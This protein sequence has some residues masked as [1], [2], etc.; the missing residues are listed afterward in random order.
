LESLKQS[1]QNHE[2][3]KEIF[4]LMKK[5]IQ[6]LIERMEINKRINNK[7]YELTVILRQKVLGKH[8]TFLIFIHFKRSKLIPVYDDPL[9]VSVLA[10]A[11]GDHH[12]R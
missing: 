12:Y 5:L 10:D 7:E 3:K 8:P 6:T 9:V 1:S 4:K 11:V 2:E